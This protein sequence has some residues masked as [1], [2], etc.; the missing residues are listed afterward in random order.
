[1]DKIADGK[2]N[3]PGRNCTWAN[4]G[5]GRSGGSP[6]VVA[7]LVERQQAEGAVRASWALAGPNEVEGARSTGDERDAA[8]LVFEEQKQ[9]HHGDGEDDD[10]GSWRQ[11]RRE[12]AGTGRI[13]RL[14][15][16]AEEIRSRSGPGRELD[17]RLW[18]CK[19]MA[20]EHIQR[21]SGEGERI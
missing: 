17:G 8:A 18:C 4:S 11:G 10:R 1:M 7:Q 21:I 13:W 14:G 20:G 19:D 3:Y 2:K 9:Q 5:R 12:P 16:G 15:G 6:G